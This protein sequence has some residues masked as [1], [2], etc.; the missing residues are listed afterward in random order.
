MKKLLFLLLI[1]CGTSAAVVSAASSS[2]RTVL[3][4]SVENGNTTTIYVGAV[5]VEPQDDGSLVLAVLP[6]VVKTD[7]AGKEIYRGIDPSGAF[8]LTLPAIQV[9]AISTAV[10]GAYDTKIAEAATK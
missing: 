10:K 3:S 5:S 9:A 6:L 1:A 8:K 7:S 2:A 4:S